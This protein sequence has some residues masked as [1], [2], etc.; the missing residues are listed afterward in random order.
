MST[1]G[2]AGSQGDEFARTRTI[3]NPT[4]GTVHEPAETTRNPSL[5][6]LHPAL[7]SAPPGTRPVETGPTVGFRTA[8]ASEED[9]FN[10]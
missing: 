2:D 4:T 10:G 3:P 8:A 7:S 9:V 5:T 6:L 1:G